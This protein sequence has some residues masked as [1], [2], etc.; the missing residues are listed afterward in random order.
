[1]EKVSPS[2]TRTSHSP[3]AAVYDIERG[4]LDKLRPYLWQTDT[5]VG[6]KSWGYI[7]GEEFRTPDSLVDDLVDIT[8]KN[9]LMLLNI[10]P[11]ADGSIPDQAQKVLLEIGKWLEL[12][13]E[14][15]YGT[16]PWVIFGEGPTPVLTGGFT[17]R[18]QK[19]FTSEDIR[20]T[21]KGGTLYAIALEWPGKTLIIRSFGTDSKIL[22]KRIASV[23]LLGSSE[24][25]KWKQDAGGLSV[26]FPK[27][28]S[29]NYAHALRIETN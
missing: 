16:R 13:G 3:K 19:S 2:T 6:L 17:D 11:R 25:L 12:N 21:S 1:M 9:G 15:I 24:R 18:K 4:K 22:D 28:K 20:F 29:G 14:A 10:G 7:E 5:S 26:E 27:T 23:K 8:S